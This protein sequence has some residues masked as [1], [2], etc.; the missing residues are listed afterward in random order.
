[1]NLK[2]EYSTLTFPN[3]YDSSLHSQYLPY[4][5]IQGDSHP[6]SKPLYRTQRQLQKHT[7]MWSKCRKQ[8][9]VRLS[10]PTDTS[11]TQN[12]TAKIQRISEGAVDRL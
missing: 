11:T 8:L 1:M 2:G 5:H 10:A 12:A 9:T 4:P 6:V 7:H 3:Q